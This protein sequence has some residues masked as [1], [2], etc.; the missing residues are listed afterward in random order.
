[1]LVRP[2]LLLL[3]LLTLVGYWRENLFHSSVSQFQCVKYRLPCS[4]SST[5]KNTSSTVLLLSSMVSKTASSAGRTVSASPGQ[6]LAGRRTPCYSGSCARSSPW[7]G[8]AGSLPEELPASIS[9]S[10]SITTVEAVLMVCVSSWYSG[11]LGTLPVLL[12]TGL[13][14]LR[15]ASSNRTVEAVLVFLPLL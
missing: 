15:S 3:G 6:T 11:F 13:L 1:M 9:S 7:V 4:S 5:G 12:L 8:R 14:N 2:L 10:S